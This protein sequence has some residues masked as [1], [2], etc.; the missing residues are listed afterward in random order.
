M[1]LVEFY[2]PWCGHCKALSPTWDELGEK[3]EGRDDIMIAKME[4]TA[5]DV[6]NVS[7]RSYPTLILFKG[8]ISN[9]VKYEEGDRSLDGLLKFLRKHGIKETEKVEKKKSKKKEEL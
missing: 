5:N 4:A 3:L 9:Q 8:S 6:D 2:A 7:V 1:Y